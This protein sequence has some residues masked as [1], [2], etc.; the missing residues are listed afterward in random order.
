MTYY[1]RDLPHWHPTGKSLFITWRLYGSLRPGDSSKSPPVVYRSAGRRFRE[2]DSSLDA[3]RCGPVWL[4][5][6]RVARSVVETILRGSNLLRQYELHAYVVMANHVHLLITPMISV[7]RIT[8][9][10]K[11]VTAREANVILER[12]GKRFWQGESFDH[13]VRNA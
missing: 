1:K 12:I 11:G 10:V 7:A 5:D 9:G 3:A 13:W 4:K 6:E 8:N 2:M